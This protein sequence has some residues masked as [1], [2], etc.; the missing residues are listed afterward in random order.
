MTAK[1]LKTTTGDDMFQTPY[2]LYHSKEWLRFTARLK[3]DRIN[4]DGF[5]ICAHCG[6]PIIKKY[7][8]IAHHTVELTDENVNDYLIS[9]NPDLIELVH[10]ACHNSKHKRAKGIQNF[11]Q[12]VYIVYGSPCSG[13][14]T[15]VNEQATADDLIVDLDSI[16]ECL[17]VADRYHKPA[18]LKANVFGVRDC[19]IDQIKTRKGNWRN[20]YIIGGYPLATDRERLSQMLRAEL[21]FIDEDFETCISRAEND[22]WKKFVEDW[23]DAYTE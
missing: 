2:D 16:W 19:L 3:N 17:S 15:W 7:D 10:F 14:T 18:R 21:V 8:C 6:K 5:I 9:F 12:D 20:A 13:K 22:D 23:F 11:K 4:E 1:K